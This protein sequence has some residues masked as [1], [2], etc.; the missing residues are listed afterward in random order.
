MEKSSRTDLKL[1]LFTFGCVAFCAGAV[2]GGLNAYDAF[3]QIHL[4]PQEGGVGCVVVVDL[5][6]AACL[7][8]ISVFQ[9][10]KRML[11]LIGMAAILVSLILVTDYAA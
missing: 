10:R 11:V 5:P 6:I 3:T 8:C 9:P 2:L 4:G 7:L 1:A